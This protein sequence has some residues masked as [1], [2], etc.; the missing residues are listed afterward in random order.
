V[1]WAY[2][3]LGMIAT[4]VL[5]RSLGLGVLQTRWMREDGK[6]SQARR[7]RNFLFGLWGGLVIAWIGSATG[8]FILKAA[9]YALAVGSV[10]ALPL[11]H[12]RDS[13]RSLGDGAEKGSAS[14]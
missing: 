14:D 8:L 12:G 9:G 4:I 11:G 13:K 5:F 10:V 6:P 7:Y 2:I 3:A 1:I